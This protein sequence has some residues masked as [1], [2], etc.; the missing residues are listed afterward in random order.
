VQADLAT[1]QVWYNAQTYANQTL[2]DLDVPLAAVR[3]DASTDRSGIAI[4]AKHIPLLERTRGRQPQFTQAETELA[5]MIL[6]VAGNSYPEASSLAAVGTDLDYAV[7]WPTPRFPL[8][9]PERDLQDK[10]EMDEG[11]KSLI[12]VVAERNGQT[13]EQAKEHIERV[14]EDNKWLATIL[15]P[16]PAPDPATVDDTTNL[17]AEAKAETQ[18]EGE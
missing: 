13:A 12:D 18:A 1:E 4:V 6:T 3:M 8:P 10:W 15:P 2:E 11:I 7:T 17:Q 14:A 5:E 9:T 16:P